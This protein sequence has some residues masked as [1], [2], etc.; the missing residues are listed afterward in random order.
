MKPIRRFKHWLNSWFGGTGAFTGARESQARSTIP[1]FSPE[2][3]RILPPESRYQL[4]KKANWLYN[5]TGLF[6]AL[7]N[8]PVRYAVGRGINP[9]AATKDAEWNKLADEWFERKAR[10]KV[11][12][13][14]RQQNF[15]QMQRSIVRH[16][17]RDGEC[18]VL[19][20]K[21]SKGRRLQLI[22]SAKIGFNTTST[23]INNPRAVDGIE[24]DDYGAPLKF[25][26]KE[27]G[28]RARE[29]DA[30]NVLH[31]YDPER[32]GLGR[33]L[34]WFYHGINNG[35]DIHD[36]VSLEKRAAKVH[37][38]FAAAVKKKSGAFGESNVSGLGVQQ[39]E[40]RNN[41]N[42]DKIFG[43]QTVYLEP[44]ED[45]DLIQSNRPNIELIQFL[46]FLGRDS[47]VGGGANPEFIWNVSE[48]GGANTR[49]ILADIQV[50][51]STIQDILV[52]EFCIHFRRY[53]LTGAMEDGELPMCKD[54]NFDNARWHTPPSITV[55][56]GREGKLYIDLVNN[57]LMTLDQYW[58]MQGYD[59]RVM[60]EQCIREIA[61]D[62]DLCRK[63]GVPYDRYRPPTIKLDPIQVQ[64]EKDAK[65]TSKTNTLDPEESKET[66]G[67]TD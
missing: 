18:F 55:D 45:L 42:L 58:S 67:D 33:G 29:V 37:S 17:M 19:L 41:P 9:S 27:I 32:A 21:D 64:E 13:V 7:V 22:E 62:L 34:P 11:W 15:W 6:K 23:A 1:D 43:G 38:A 52:E 3:E 66:E 16:M 51:L 65:G 49:Y 20:I 31:I 47:T 60:R 2:G 25:H 39:D 8:K 10:T 36:L 24:Y 61:E 50:L 40:P 12:D 46:E 59:P 14:A 5:N 28:T 57:G 30:D 35:I 4:V 44:D 54:P 26:I 48:M 56:R 53:V 63:L